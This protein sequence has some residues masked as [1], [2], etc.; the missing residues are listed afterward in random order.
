MSDIV[1][2]QLSHLI[3]YIGEAL[4]KLSAIDESTDDGEPHSSRGRILVK[5]IRE[6]MIHDFR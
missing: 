1:L 2:I 3:E 5:T 6:S 4:I